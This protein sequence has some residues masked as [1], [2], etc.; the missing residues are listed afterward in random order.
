MHGYATFTS[1]PVLCPTRAL[2]IE[3]KL[4]RPR[5][6]TSRPQHSLIK[7]K[8]FSHSYSHHSL[9]AAYLI[10]H[11]RC[12]HSSSAYATTTQVTHN[13]SHSD[14][15]S[16]STLLRPPGRRQI[17]HPCHPTHHP[18]PAS[19]CHIHRHPPFPT[20]QLIIYHSQRRG[21]SNTPD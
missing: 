12:S 10:T 5:T 11:R 4:W 14:P 2:R 7:K 16:L 19:P 17:P 13:A 21:C 1:S 15:F 20:Y 3:N 18:R 9:P 8:P 6:I